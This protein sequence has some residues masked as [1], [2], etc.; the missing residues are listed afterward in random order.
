MKFKILDLFCGAGGFSWGM[1]KNS[2]FSTEIALDLNP[3]AAYTFKQNMPSAAVIVGDI[4]C[5]DIK[6][7]VIKE[8]KTR[9][10]N[11]IIG[12]P[13]CQGFSLKGKKL[14]LDDPRNF[15]FR[16]YLDIVK[17]LQPEVFIIENVKAI[18]STSTGWFKNEILNT[19]SS[20]GYNIGYG[21]V[22]AADYGVPQTRERAIFLCSK[23]KHISLPSPV[24]RKISV[25][26]AISDLAYLGIFS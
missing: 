5:P 20:L 2:N 19:I 8:S 23:S 10:V 22:N 7:R 15:L 17:E 16:E 21:V 1:H 24:G 4:T 3:H 18:L 25:R 9:G 12:G 6:L 13:P 11:M 26:E 14:G